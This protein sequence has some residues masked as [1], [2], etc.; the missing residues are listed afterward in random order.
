MLSTDCT[1]ET[2]EAVR[3]RRRKGGIMLKLRS[4]GLSDYSVREGRH[5]PDSFSYRTNAVRLDLEC[6]SA[7]E[8]RPYHEIGQGPRHREG[9]V[10]GGSEALKAS[11]TPEQ[12]AAAYKAMN[13]SDDD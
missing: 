1:T 7:P 13:I 12:L 8:R 5:R 9:R 10:E 11:T 2:R 3:R 6:P 4:L